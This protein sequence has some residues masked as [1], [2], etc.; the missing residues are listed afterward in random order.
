MLRK[1]AKTGM[2]GTAFV[3]LILAAMMIPTSLVLDDP[4][5]DVRAGICE[6]SYTGTIWA[7]VTSNIGRAMVGATVHLAGNGTWTT[8]DTGVARITGLLAD[9]NGTEYTLW[10]EM[11][12]FVTSAPLTITVTPSNTAYLNLT[13]RG[14]VVVGT[15][16]EGGVAIAQADV[17]IPELSMNTSTASDGSYQ[18][19][20]IK[21][22]TYSVIATALNHD[23]LAKIT[24]VPIGGTVALYFSLSSLTGGISGFVLHSETLEPLHRANVSVVVGA[25]TITVA[26]DQ[27]GSYYLPNLPAGV[28]SLT[29]NLDGFNSSAVHGIVV[30]SGVTTDEVNLL[31]DE[32]TTRL[33]GVVKAGTVLL[34]GANVTVVG[35]EHYGKTSIDGEYE[36]IGIPAGTYVVTASLQGYN[37]MSVFQ[38]EIRRGFEAQLNFN[39]TGLPGALY[40]IVVDEETGD[41]L[42]GVQVVVLPQR[43]TITNINGEFEFTGLK[44][45]EYMVRFTLDGY[46]PIEIG[47]VVITLEETTEVQTIHMEPTRESFGGF[48]FGFDLPHSMMIL[49]LFLTI[50]I[51]A[52][53][54]VLRIRTFEAPDKA[55]AVYDDLDEEQAEEEPEAAD[56]S[57]LDEEAASRENIG[58]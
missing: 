24:T 19:N 46:R 49:A 36:I 55:P 43:E 5:C 21:S 47:P 27:N 7:N 8:N 33:W 57:L 29:A 4:S 32:K 39:L 9:T 28:Y 20:G 14:G 15:V 56:G 35:T 16:S 40:G 44:A 31:L 13:V 58:E 23:P 25:L 11:D 26:T 45:G 50:V 10:A 53:A 34:V 30:E 6:E 17:A 18:L 38:V 22:G 41:Y 54:V 12:G 37:N 2:G 1:L 42:A 48:V 52:F 3:A 51:L